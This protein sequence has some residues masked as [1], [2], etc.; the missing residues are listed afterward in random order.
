MLCGRRR[1]TRSCEKDSCETGVY[2]SRSPPAI[3]KNSLFLTMSVARH[4]G[5]EIF[6][7]LRLVGFLVSFGLGFMQEANCKAFFIQCILTSIVCSASLSYPMPV[8]APKMAKE[9][10]A[11][12]L[13]SFPFPHTSFC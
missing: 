11:D 3:H 4:I 6:L 2:V 8:A 5:P 1:S 13:L 12:M 10:D 9:V 7:L